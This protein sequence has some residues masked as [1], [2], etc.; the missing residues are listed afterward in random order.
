MKT[1]NSI[2][3]LLLLS[4]ALVISSCATDYGA[5]F[6][7]PEYQ[8]QAK[9]KVVKVPT[10]LIKPLLRSELAK[11]EEG[12]QLMAIVKKLKKIKLR[13]GTVE[14]PAL[15]NEFNRYLTGRNFQD[16]FVVRSKGS[17]ISVRATEN[18]DW[19]KDLFITINNG[20]QLTLLDIKGNFTFQEITDLVN[21]SNQSK[22]LKGV[23]K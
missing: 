23:A 20:K 17:I 14:D 10:F 9:M 12:K 22:L 5:F 7:R 15:V 11:E 3:V 1:N 16:W 2:K 6:D 18:G 8:N 4:I 21:S 19:V 13:T